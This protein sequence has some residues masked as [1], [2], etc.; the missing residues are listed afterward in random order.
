MENA[1]EVRKNKGKLLKIC[2]AAAIIL[3]CGM[4]FFMSAVR[5]EIPTMAYTEITK[6]DII[7]SLS[8][9]GTVESIEKHNIYATLGFII[10]QVDVE[11]GDHIRAG[12]TLA[13]LDTENLELDIAGRKAD[14]SISQESSLK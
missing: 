5:G 2:A 4:A 7:N 3:V 10:K 6:G 1:I 14:L 9:K 8:A 11:V 13:I 12:Q